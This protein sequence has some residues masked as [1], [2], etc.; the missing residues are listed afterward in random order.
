MSDD[1]TST[2]SETQSPPQAGTQAQIPPAP[3]SHGQSSLETDVE[4]PG[5]ALGDTGKLDHIGQDAEKRAAKRRK[6]VIGSLTCLFIVITISLSVGL[7]VG[8]SVTN[9]K[10]YVSLSDA[11]RVSDVAQILCVFI[12]LHNKVL[13]IGRCTD[14][15]FK[16]K[17]LERVAVPSE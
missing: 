4:K 14:E 11:I 12:E 1:G 9:S 2:F 10:W 13:G 5:A 7:S 17:M 8:L 3:R 15:T 16:V 6:Y